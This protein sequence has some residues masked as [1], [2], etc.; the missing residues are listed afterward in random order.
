MIRKTI[1]ALAIGAAALIP[2]V[3]SAKHGHHGH[4]GFRG[5]G[6]FGITIVDRSDDC[7]WTWVKVGHRTY[8]K[9]YVC[10]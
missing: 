10:S 3:A 8:K 4:H 2:T 9:V 5:F 1:F 6:G 7:G